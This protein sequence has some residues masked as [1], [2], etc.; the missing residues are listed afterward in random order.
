MILHYV[1]L[2]GV[3]GRHIAFWMGNLN[4]RDSLNNL[5]I[6]DDDLK[7]WSSCRLGSCVS[8]LES[9]AVT[10]VKGNGFFASI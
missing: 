9:V 5:G 2:V 6:D 8:G 1:T 10:C 4:E 3:R 7:K